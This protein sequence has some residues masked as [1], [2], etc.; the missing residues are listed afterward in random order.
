MGSKRVGLARV[1]ALIENLKR[2]LALGSKAGVSFADSTGYGMHEY[3]EVVTLSTSDDDDVSAS[4]SKYIPARAIILDAAL[5]AVELATSNHGA[6][7]LEVHS[8][9]VADDAASAGTEIVG[10]DV[11]GNVSVPDS[12]L[13]VSSDANLGACIS[14]GTLAPVQRGANASY[15]HVTSKEDQSSMTGTPKVGVWVKWIGPAMVDA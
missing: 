8:A 12:D 5:I 13:D 3:F 6:A 7:A 11:A 2:D 9:A 10:A 14:F 15:L 1:Q 4:L